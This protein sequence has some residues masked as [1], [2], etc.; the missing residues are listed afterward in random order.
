[1]SNINNYMI[2]FYILGTLLVIAIFLVV[3]VAKKYK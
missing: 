1:M 2:N 3:L